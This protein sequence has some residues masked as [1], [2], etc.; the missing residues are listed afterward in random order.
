MRE[1]VIVFIR[2]NCVIIL[3]VFIGLV[4]G[5]NTFYN[6][7]TFKLLREGFTNDLYSSV[8]FRTE[9]MIKGQ[10]MDISFLYPGFISATGQTFSVFLA[11]FL[12]LF[13]PDR[14]TTY[15]YY[16][17]V[18]IISFLTF[19]VSLMKK[20]DR[21]TRIIGILFSIAF[22]ISGAGFRGIFLGNTDILLAS[23]TGI[24][25]LIVL[26]I[27]NK[28]SVSIIWIFVLG[29][30]AGSLVNAK[31]FLLPFALL[32]VIFS[33]RI[34]LTGLITVTTFLALIYTPNLFG[35]LSSLS[36][37]INTIMTWNN[38]EIFQNHYW[39]NHSIYMVATLFTRCLDYNIFFNVGP[40]PCDN[41]LTNSLISSFIFFVVFAIPFLLVKPLK[42]LSNIS[43]LLRRLKSRE[44][45]LAA[46]V[47]SDAF[48]NL[49][50][51]IVYDYRLFF[52]PIVTLILF[53]ETQRFNK[54]LKYCYLSIFSLLIGGIWI[55][56][57]DLSQAWRID[58]RLLKF[59]I[60][61]HYFFLIL[62]VLTYWKE[63]QAK[64]ILR[65][66]LS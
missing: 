55:L 18:V 31:I 59:F 46:F 32:A 37:Y 54:A 2:R 39:A 51:K 63:S 45:A 38:L 30:L 21:K 29:I 24:L 41:S 13:S 26:N 35:S 48:I 10:I 52:S 66:K 12:L 34:I 53:K 27:I 9:Q 17:I 3:A 5:V 49:S 7:A 36:L 33:K 23:L 28:K 19:F 8:Y 65:N 44:S 58:A 62:S 11:P 50:F 22:F 14:Y 6:Y 57:L 4:L 25:I 56:Q 47:L 42:N 20:A 40:S 15:F 60:L 43:Y 61:F 64:R 16:M 1:K